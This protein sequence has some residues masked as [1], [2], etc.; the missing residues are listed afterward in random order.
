MPERWVVIAK[1]FIPSL[2]FIFCSPACPLGFLGL[3][4]VITRLR[5]SRNLSAQHLIKVAKWFLAT[6]WKAF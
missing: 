6:P 5:G 3:V 2:F 1:V 4:L